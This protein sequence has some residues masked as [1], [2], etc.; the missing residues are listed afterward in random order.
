MGSR[1][2]GTNVHEIPPNE[3]RMTFTISPA[4]EPLAAKFPRQAGSSDSQLACTAAVSDGRDRIA[5]RL[6]D[7]I[8]R[9]MFGVGLRLQATAQLA[10]LAV[11]ARLVLAI[12]DLDLII[13]EVRSVIFD[14]NPGMHLSS[15]E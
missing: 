11:Q 15:D 2:E 4:G 12:H 5:Q 13:A 7:D 1:I 3:S 8:I 10:D 6:N 9:E 14:R